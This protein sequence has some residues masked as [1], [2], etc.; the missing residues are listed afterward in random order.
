MVSNTFG[1][2]SGTVF[3]KNF[4]IQLLI[5]MFAQLVPP[6]VTFV[7]PLPPKRQSELWESKEPQQL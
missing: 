3:G 7:F 1:Y 2:Q 6:Y 5:T 4:N